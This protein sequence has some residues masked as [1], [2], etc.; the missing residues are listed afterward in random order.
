[1]GGLKLAVQTQENLLRD[2]L[3][4]RAIASEPIGVP[5][6]QPLMDR[7]RFFKAQAN[8]SLRV[9]GPACFCLDQ[10]ELPCAHLR[11]SINKTPRVE[12]LWRIFLG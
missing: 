3:R 8:V 7:E 6:D 11:F 1:L 12:V 10:R 4:Q 2:I 5:I 9:G